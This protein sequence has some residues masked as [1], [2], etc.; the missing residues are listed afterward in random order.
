MDSATAFSAE[1]VA[2]LGVD[3]LHLHTDLVVE[4]AGGACGLKRVVTKSMLAL[5][6]LA[7]DDTSTSCPCRP[8]PRSV[9]IILLAFAGGHELDE[10]AARPP[11]SESLFTLESHCGQAGSLVSPAG[12]PSCQLVP[13][14]PCPWSHRSAARRKTSEPVGKRTCGRRS[15]CREHPGRSQLHHPGN[16]PSPIICSNLMVLTKV[17]SMKSTPSPYW[18]DSHT[19]ISRRGASHAEGQRHQ[20]LGL[21]FLLAATIGW[22]PYAR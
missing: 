10:L 4:F 15:S 5:A 9:L 2:S 3:V 14:Q 16:R 6:G 8:E 7:S 20:T 12:S 11:S 19:K 22:A 17:S 1:S 21:E 13:S 18:L